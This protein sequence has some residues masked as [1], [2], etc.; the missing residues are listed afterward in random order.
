[1]DPIPLSVLNWNLGA[2]VAGFLASNFFFG[3]LTMQAIKYHSQFPEDRWVTKLLV[4][5]V[6][7]LELGQLGCVYHA[8]YTITIVRSGDITALLDP[9]RTVGAA[10]LLASCIGPAAEAY[11]VSRLYRY[12]TH[13][14]PAALGWST[15]LVRLGGWIFLSVQLIKLGSISE[16]KTKFGWLFA[17][18]LAVSAFIDLAV[19]GWIGYF[20]GKHRQ[21]GR[22]NSVADMLDRAIIGTLKTGVITSIAFLGT[23]VCYLVLGDHLVWMAVSAVLTK[24]SSTCLL[25]TLNARPALVADPHDG[26]DMEM[27]EQRPADEAPEAP[28]LVLPSTLPELSSEIH[29]ALVNRSRFS[30][31]TVSLRLDVWE[32]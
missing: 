26:F 9:P 8:I 1:M 12:S 15:A 2:L 29:R 4:G 11:Y 19:A 25:A 16:F 31:D 17:I 5:A 20:L 14:Y 27:V 21:R 22:S 28:E 10:F 6:W 30:R 7:T 32:L 24:V 18:L 3:I 23:L 13:I